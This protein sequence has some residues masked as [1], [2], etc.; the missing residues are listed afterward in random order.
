MPS[1]KILV[2]V[3]GIFLL[4]AL[5]IGA[6]ASLLGRMLEKNIANF[7]YGH[8]SGSLWQG[9]FTH[10][11]YDGVSLG[12]VDYR[13]KFLPLL[14]GKAE[15]DLEL[16]G[17]A[18]TGNISIGIGKNYIAA[19]NGD[20]RARLEGITNNTAFGLPVRGIANVNLELLHLN[21]EGCQQADFSLWTDFL[22]L[23]AKQFGGQG[24]PME[25]QGQCEG[26][27]LNLALAGNGAE[28]NAQ[29]S[30]L[31]RPDMG[32]KITASAA[33]SN[34]DIIEALAFL[35]FEKKG[36]QLNYVADGVL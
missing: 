30:F 7:S 1:R 22:T 29:L 17:G 12:R 9:Q 33:P 25:G 31:I 11:G 15:F 14:T 3:S 6:P 19:S 16:N 28:G 5:V 23:P 35:G 34:P 4:S 32:Y 36:E 24:F 2:F 27:D 10:A 8:V 20:L 13:L 21:G 18:L 26:A